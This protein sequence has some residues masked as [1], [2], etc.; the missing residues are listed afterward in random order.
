[1]KRSLKKSYQMDLSTG[2]ILG[3]LLRFTLPLML[4]SLLQ[5]LFNAADIVVVGR[6]A[7]DTALAAVGSNS[8]LIT[9][10]TN[11]FMGLSIGTNVLAARSLGA[12]DDEQ[13]HSTVHTSVLVSLLSGLLLIFVGLVG[14]D[15]VAIATDCGASIGP[16]RHTQK[17]Y[18]KLPLFDS[19]WPKEI[20]LAPYEVTGEMWDSMAWTNFPLF[21][22]GMV[23]RGIPDDDIRKILGGN[24]LRVLKE[25]LV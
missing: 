13:L 24:Y 16:L 17:V 5:L 7:G 19:W 15:H 20:P 8:S 18:R 12:K 14:A 11:I 4:S 1:M 21:T 25:T 10:I 23:Q 9:L 6:F 3:K 22:V 2:P